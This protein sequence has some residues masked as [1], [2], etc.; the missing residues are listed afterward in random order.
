MIGSSQR[1]TFETD[2]ESVFF[3]NKREMLKMQGFKKR[4]NKDIYQA[5]ETIRK[6]ELQP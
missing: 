1:I 5:N 4:L 6:Q 3:F 2:N